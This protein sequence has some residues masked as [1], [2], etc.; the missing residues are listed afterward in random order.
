MR[1]FFLVLQLTLAEKWVLMVL[2]LVI[3]GV[4]TGCFALPLPIMV[5]K[6]VL[7]LAD[8]RGRA[9][10][11]LMVCTTMLSSAAAA[12]FSTMFLVLRLI[13][14]PKLL[15]RTRISFLALTCFLLSL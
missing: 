1:T 10:D 14:L 11:K 13:F 15:V 4:T 5:L 9:L 8:F 12:G 7:L 2:L 3:L 6:K